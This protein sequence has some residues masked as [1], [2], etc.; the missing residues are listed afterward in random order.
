MVAVGADGINGDTYN[1][2]PR[3][4]FD[5]CDAAR[6]AGGAAAGVHDQRRGTPD[7]ERAELGQEGAERDRDPPVAKF[8]WLEPRH[9][10]NYENRW[11]RDRN[12]DLQYIFFNGIGYNAWE[13][14]WGIW[15]QLTA[16]RRRDAAPH[17]DHRA[18]FAP[19]MVSMDWRPYERR[20]KRGVFASRFPGEGLHACGPW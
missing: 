10:I 2:V 9:M 16:A 13:N 17:R 4:F 12:N 5:A 15:N 20:C 6:P 3:A 14:I 8:K 11:G 7:L 1:G 19:L 18:P